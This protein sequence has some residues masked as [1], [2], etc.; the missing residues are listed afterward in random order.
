MSPDLLAH[1]MV[2]VQGAQGRH[3]EVNDAVEV[4]AAFGG[5]EIGVMVGAMLVAASKRH[6]IMVDGMAA[7]AALMIASRIATAV[8]DYCVF[9]RSHDHQGLDNALGLF[10]ATALLE[11]GMQ[12]TDGTG[13]ALAWACSVSWP[14]SGST[15]CGSSVSRPTSCLRSVRAVSLRLR[16][17]RPRK[18]LVLDTMPPM[19][20]SIGVI[21]PSVS[22]PTMM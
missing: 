10:R 13:A 16:D 19:P 22:W 11:L 21:E 3:R 20:R 12:S 1:L 8:T 15:S 2:I 17:L 9:C 4:L 7:C 14:P 5:F 6:L 18:S